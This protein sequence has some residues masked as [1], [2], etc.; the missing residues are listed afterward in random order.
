MVRQNDGFL[1]YV[2]NDPKRHYGFSFASH[3]Y[4]YICLLIQG[5]RLLAV[6]GIVH[7]SRT[8]NSERSGIRN[9]SSW[10]WTD[11]NNNR[12]KVIFDVLS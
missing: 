1:S 2:M 10:S 3:V 11:S 12:L 4:R 8:L 5:L 6:Y 9:T 7:G